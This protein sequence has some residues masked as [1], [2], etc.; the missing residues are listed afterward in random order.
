M[1]LVPASAGQLI[2]VTYQVHYINL[3]SLLDKRRNKLRTVSLPVE[4][5]PHRSCI[6]CN[7]DLAINE[8]GQGMP[9][10]DPRKNSSASVSLLKD[11]VERSLR[12]KVDAKV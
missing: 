12:I 9:R 6:R 2:P 4:I 5:Y 1:A 3:V 7:H 11:D 10:Y 8:E